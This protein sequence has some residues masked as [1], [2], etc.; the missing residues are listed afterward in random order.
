MAK[1]Y[2]SSK[3]GT[4]ATRLDQA[5][6]DY[7]NQALS[8]KDRIEALDFMIYVFDI[9]KFSNEKNELN[10]IL[11]NL[12]AERESKKQE[13]PNYIPV[14]SSGKYH[15]EK[16]R[17]LKATTST[18][19]SPEEDI[20]R[21]FNA[22]NLLDV[23][24]QDKREDKYHGTTYLTPEERAEYSIE[25]HNGLLHKEG[26][27]FDSSRLIAHDKRG[28]VAFTLNAN[29]EL[30]VFEHLSMTLDKK[31]RKLAHSSMNAGAPVLSA[32]EMEIKNGKLISINTYSGHYE[33][34]LYSVARFLEYLSDRGVDISET[35]VFL[36]HP[37]GK[38]SGL[39]SKPVYLKGDKQPWH[40]VSATDIVHS[41]KSIMKSNLNSLDDYLNSTK[42]ILLRDVFQNELTQAKSAIAQNFYDEL[43]FTMDM[44]KDSSSLAD[45]N[46]SLECLESII[47]RHSAELEQ[48]NGKTGRLDSK[49]A[50]MKAQIKEAREKLE[51]I[52]DTSENERVESFKSSF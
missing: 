7:K 15:F 6:A 33:P 13:N 32:G 4:V 36:Q 47:T 27:V 31:G 43:L 17:V 39:Q 1:N 49:F 41:V 44:M 50:E 52:D 11:T 10:K 34:S 26:K 21:D 28:F 25:I 5:W 45:I 3:N 2:F 14:L 29:G 46:T 30:S 20:Q 12:M 22:G 9:K 19:I 51:G 38:E 42:T 23:N 16:A 35:K 8:D 37:P 18:K 40:E 48:L 24:R